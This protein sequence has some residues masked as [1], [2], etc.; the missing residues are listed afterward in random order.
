MEDILTTYEREVHRTSDGMYTNSPSKID[1][2][3]RACLGLTGEAGECAD[4]IKKAA[5]YNNYVLTKEDEENLIKEMGDVLFYLTNMAFMLNVDLK[6]VINEN[7]A[8][9]HRRYENGFT[10]EESKIH[11]D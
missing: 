2:L 6:K 1:K 4:I 3:M 10:I 9:S 7:I 5:D 8:K 11:K